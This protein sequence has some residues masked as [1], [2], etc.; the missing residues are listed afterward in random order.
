MGPGGERAPHWDEV[1]EP[2]ANHH[3]APSAENTHPARR[4]AG[5]RFRV[6]G[7][8]IP[9]GLQLCP[10]FRH[11]LRV[12]PGALSL[13]QPRWSARSHIQIHH[14]RFGDARRKRVGAWR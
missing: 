1:A 11:R 12:H 4:I 10:G 13:G 2:A 7:H 8:E 14:R 9:E 3:D 5:F 6:L